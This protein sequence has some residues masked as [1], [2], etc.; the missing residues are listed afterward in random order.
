MDKA[1]VMLNYLRDAPGLDLLAFQFGKVEA[2]GVT[3]NTVS[4]DAV[5]TQ[6]I[7]GGQQKQFDFAIAVYVDLSDDPY[8]TD[9]LTNWCSVQKFGDWIKAQNKN[10]IFPDFGANCEIDAVRALQDMPSVARS[11]EENT[12]KYL[13]MCRVE[14][15]E[16]ED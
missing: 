9:N 1:A 3:F 4:S 8:V 13:Y 11:Q 10:R 16:Y 12:A 5:I 6:Y 7:D 15:V 14:Y 2:G